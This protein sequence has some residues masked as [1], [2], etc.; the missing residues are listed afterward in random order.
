[1]NK[2]LPEPFWDLI[3]AKFLAILD[4]A[5]SVKLMDEKKLLMNDCLGNV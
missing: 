3:L 2:W 4:L 1:M 5:L